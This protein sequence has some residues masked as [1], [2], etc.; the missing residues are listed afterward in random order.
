MRRLI[1]HGL[2]ALACWLVLLSPESLPAD[3][4]PSPAFHAG[5]VL[6]VRTG[7][8]T[9]FDQLTTELTAVEVIYLGEE[10]Q[11]RSHI[12]AGLKILSALLKQDRRPVL[13]LEMFGW[14]G[15]A[16]LDRYLA[17]PDMPRDRFLEEARWK[18][19]WGGAFEEYEPL[20][21]FARTHRL[22]TLALNPPKPLVRR[23]A[24]EGWQQAQGDPEMARWGMPEAVPDDPAYRERIFTQLR[25]CHPGLS[26]D[27]YQRMYEAS[28]FRDEGMA[29]TI[30]DAL[31]RLP[32]GG[33]PIV[34]YTGGGHIQYR[35]PVPNRVLR[36]AR[37]AL[38]QTTIYLTSFAPDRAAEIRTLLRDSIADYVW[39]TP[40][41]PHGPTRRC[42]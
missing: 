41:S 1:L 30:T 22:V 10:H 6:D 39:L 16:G 27:L 28:L 23:V 3:G 9:T 33:G 13:G 32:A 14:D 15:Q 20:I 5:D 2:I 21:S 26:E 12:E 24:T 11:H 40:L 35:L 29:K 25:S 36:R 7:R 42:L 37:R 34:S 8:P 17:D 31:R 38:R 4:D 19:N 18:Q